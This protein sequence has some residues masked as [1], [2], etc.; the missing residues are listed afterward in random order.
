LALATDTVEKT[1]VR[2]TAP[3]VLLALSFSH[4]LNDLTQSIVPAVYPLLKENFSLSFTQIGLIALTLQLTAS[5]FQPFVGL[6]TDKRPLPYS[7]PVGMAFS[8]VGLMLMALAPHYSILILAAAA[9]GVGSSVFHPESSR[10]ARMASGGRH[11]LA[12][13]VFQVGG[14]FGTALGPLVAALIIM[15][16]G[17]RSIAWFSAG[18]LI[19]MVVLWNIGSWSKRQTG[20]RKS[21][22]VVEDTSGLS[23]RTVAFTIGVLLVLIFSKYFYLTSLF[24]YYTFYLISKFG[25]TTENAQL[26]LFAFMFA[27]ALGTL[28]GGP[29]GDRIG[30]RYV[31]WVSIL[32]VLPF[33]LALPHANLFW[34]TVLSIVI[35]LILS[36]AFSAIIVYAQELVPGRV[37]LI[38]GLF[39]GLAFGLS[40]IGAALLGALADRTSIGFVY[41]LCAFLPALG[42]FAWFLPDLRPPPRPAAQ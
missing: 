27:V 38:A 7:L 34:T 17:Q 32:G 31:I 14:N 15:P 23:R 36:S 24:N 21:R 41:W 10:V 35:G 22:A 18:A 20:P 30:R 16:H 12:Q 26:H 19:A 9:I 1:V 25:V 37:G 2:G 28:I 3:A 42:V 40:G 11:G 6:Y 29:V 8:F 13:S 33:T 5:I 4:M 39:F